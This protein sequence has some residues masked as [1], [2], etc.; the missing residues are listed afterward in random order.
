V[1]SDSFRQFLTSYLFVGVAP[2]RLKSSI[3]G[4]YS[5]IE[6]RIARVSD[7]QRKNDDLL[8]ALNGPLATRE[9]RM[10]VAAWIAVCQFN[11]RIFGGFVRDWIVG[12]YSSQPS[13]DIDP[14][15]WI[16]YDRY[17]D[18]Q[19]G[20]QRLPHLHKEVVPN[21]IDCYLP[22]NDFDIDQFL[23]SL[24]KY[25]IECTVICKIWRGY[26]LLLDE[27]RSPFTMDLILAHSALKLHRYRILDIDVNNLCVEKDYQRSLGLRTDL[28]PSKQK[29]LVDLETIVDK[30]KNKRFTVLRDFDIEDRIEK[31][32]IR[33]WT[34]ISTESEDEYEHSDKNSN[35]D[36]DRDRKRTD[37]N[38][39]K[40]FQFVPSRSEPNPN[41]FLKLHSNQ[42][43]AQDKIFCPT[44]SC[45]VLSFIE[46]PCPTGQDEN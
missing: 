17:H 18:K 8:S 27:N 1:N 26:V 6:E 12:G 5:D 15:T 7:S 23:K 9:T 13:R 3:F 16:T 20:A 21:D 25:G 38:Q 39:A 44:L 43:R 40:T 35:D 32:T 30:I 33:G 28:I 4:Q 2:R 41:R 37:L 29:Y 19:N 46:S 36:Y 45:P 10:E 34:Q 31:M 11:C 42:R 22:D 24:R 14:S